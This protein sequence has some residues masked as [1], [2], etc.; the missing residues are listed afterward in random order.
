MTLVVGR[1]AYRE[2]VSARVPFAGT[3]VPTLVLRPWGGSFGNTPSPDCT[4]VP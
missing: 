3:G 4:D 1:H 2:E